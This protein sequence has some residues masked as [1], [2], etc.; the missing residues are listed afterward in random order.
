MSFTDWLLTD[1]LGAATTATL[2]VG[3]PPRW[4]P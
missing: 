3:V 1:E 2:A 4:W